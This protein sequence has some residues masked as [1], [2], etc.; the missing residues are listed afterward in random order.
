VALVIY[1]ERI[2]KDRRMLHALE[3]LTGLM[4]PPPGSAWW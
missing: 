4:C 3:F 1:D 2:P